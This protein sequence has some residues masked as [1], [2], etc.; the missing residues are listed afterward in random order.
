MQFYNSLDKK[1]CNKIYLDIIYHQA[2]LLFVFYLETKERNLK[3]V[4]EKVLKLKV[5]YAIKIVKTYKFFI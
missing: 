2:N 1:L 3:T 5:S 4:E